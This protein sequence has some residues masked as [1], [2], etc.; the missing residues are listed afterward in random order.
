MKVAKSLIAD[1]FH[2]FVSLF[3]FFL[4]F[5]LVSGIIPPPRVHPPQ[6]HKCRPGCQGYAMAKKSKNTAKI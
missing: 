2:F 3:H 1:I 5:C 4:L 6:Q